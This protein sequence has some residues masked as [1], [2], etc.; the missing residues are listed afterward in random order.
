[1][2]KHETGSLIT[3][4]FVLIAIYNTKVSQLLAFGMKV[5][6]QMNNCHKI[7]VWYKYMG[8]CVFKAPVGRGSVD[9]ID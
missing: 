7:I 3:C 6:C 8:S 1:M 2:L 5:K 9:T 4:L